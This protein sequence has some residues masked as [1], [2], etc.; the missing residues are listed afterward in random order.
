MVWTW[1]PPRLGFILVIWRGTNEPH[2][3][4]VT[5]PA[6][7]T[8][9]PCLWPFTLSW[10]LALTGTEE[11]TRG[12]E[13]RESKRRVAS[14]LCSWNTWMGKSETP[15]SLS[16]F[17]QRGIIGTLPEITSLMRVQR[18]RKSKDSMAL[19]IWTLIP[20]S[21]S[22]LDPNLYWNSLV[23]SAFGFLEIPFIYP[24]INLSLSCSLFLSLPTLKK[25]ILK[26]PSPDQTINFKEMKIIIIATLDYQ[27]YYYYLNTSYTRLY[28]HSEV[29]PD[30]FQNYKKANHLNMGE[31]IT[32]GL[33]FKELTKKPMTPTIRE[34]HGSCLSRAHLDI[35]HCTR[36][37]GSCLTLQDCE[38]PNFSSDFTSMLTEARKVNSVTYMTKL[39][40]L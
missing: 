20:D 38:V 4:T 10:W 19:E 15:V 13:G 5:T 9:Q 24:V 34:H 17:E 36:E 30:N 22:I 12:Q 7:E 40:N 25:R 37:R 27:H 6:Q 23:L 21:F 26:F 31:N 18:Y 28:F 11:D 33:M 16:V 1:V 39:A 8:L 29:V 35:N 32:D 3:V 2:S 14:W